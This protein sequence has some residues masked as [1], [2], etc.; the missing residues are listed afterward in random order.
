MKDAGAGWR[1]WRPDGG[2]ERRLVQR[3]HQLC[4]LLLRL[5][6]GLLL[7]LLLRAQEVLSN[8]KCA[9]C[10]IRSWAACWEESR[11]FGVPHLTARHP[12]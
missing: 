2:R 3:V 9:A 4:H 12:R 7:L 6:H 10:C 5:R 8:S 11:C 1:R